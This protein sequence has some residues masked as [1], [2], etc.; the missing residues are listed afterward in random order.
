MFQYYY[1]ISQDFF[2]I[3]YVHFYKSDEYSLSLKIGLSD[4]ITRYFAENVCG[5]SCTI[6]A[7]N[8]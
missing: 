6:L 3:K 7:M 2:S 5:L 1:V 8:S 4:H